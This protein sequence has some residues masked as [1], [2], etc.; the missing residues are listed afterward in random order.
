[1]NTLKG[2][3]KKSLSQ[4]ATGSP[5][6]EGYVFLYQVPYT[7]WVELPDGTVVQPK[8]FWGN[9]VVCKTKDMKTSIS[10]MF[11]TQVRIIKKEE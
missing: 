8:Y 6:K 10:M 4:E 5:L 9:E 3:R 1:M 7:K 2:K 11:N